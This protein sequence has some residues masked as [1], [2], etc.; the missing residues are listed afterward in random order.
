M[1]KQIW[2]CAIAAMSAFAVQGASAQGSLPLSLEARIDAGLPVGD[3]GD[4]F[5]SGVGFEL[6]GILHLT[7]MFGLYGGYSRYEF[8][9]EGF[10]NE[11]SEAEGG[12]LGG[13][14]T[15]GTGGA[16]WTPYAQ[17]GAV[18]VD[19]ETGFEGGLGAFYPVGGNLSVT[20]MARYRN[21]DDIQYVTLGVGLNMR[22]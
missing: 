4:V 11:D 1:K 20:P 8:G 13:R 3:S 18:F 17:V 2:M 5:K 7:P 12:Q 15:L 14:I 9:L 6:D 16:V 19:G 10:D 22:L 21:V